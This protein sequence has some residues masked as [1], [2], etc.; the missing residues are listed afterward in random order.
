MKTVRE[1]EIIKKETNLYSRVEKYN[2]QKEKFTT[3]SLQQ[4]CDEEKESM[5]SKIDK[6]KLPNL[7]NRE[8]D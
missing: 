6:Q 5:N 4:I 8:H 3:G 1:I 2:N 7:N